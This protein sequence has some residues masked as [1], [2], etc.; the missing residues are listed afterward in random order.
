MLQSFDSV[1]L[2]QVSVFSS[3]RSMWHSTSGDVFF[4][5]RLV[6]PLKRLVNT[7]ITHHGR[8]AGARKKKKKQLFSPSS[9]FMNDGEAMEGQRSE[10]QGPLLREYPSASAKVVGPIRHFVK[11]FS[12]RCVDN[13]CRTTNNI[14]YCTT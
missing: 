2:Q 1:D 10:V 5:G 14:T 12:L 11:Y 3:W 8:T 6:L 7:W 4:S 13:L 9:T